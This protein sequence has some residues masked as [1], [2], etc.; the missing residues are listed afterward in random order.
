MKNQPN[1]LKSPAPATLARLAKWRRRPPPRAQDRLGRVPGVAQA[2]A[3]HSLPSEAPVPAPAPP[4]PRPAAATVINAKIDVGFGN[5]PLYPGRRS[6]PQLEQGPGHGLTSAANFGSFPWPAAQPVVFKFLLNDE[7]WSSG[8]DYQ[9][10][11]GTEFD[12]Q[13]RV[14]TAARFSPD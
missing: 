8:A 1:P 6:R 3:S 2:P 5:T 10:E 11:S 14:L 9:A 7:T 12:R 4:V 13:S